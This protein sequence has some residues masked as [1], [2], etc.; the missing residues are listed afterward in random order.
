MDNDR[1]DTK[2]VDVARLAGCSPATVSRVLNNNPKVDVKVRD[3]VV[4][5]AAQLGYVPNGS[6]RALR[7]T[8][9]RTVGAII[10]TLDHAIYAT[11]VNSLQARLSE[12][13]VSVIINTSMYDIDIEFEQAKLLVERGVESVVLVGSVHR[14]ETLAMLEQRNIAY[15]FTY[16]SLATDIGAAIGF[17]NVKAGAMAARYLVDLGHTQLGMIAGIT[18]NNDRA[19]ARRDGFLGELKRQG[20]ANDNITV[21]ESAYKIEGGRDSMRKLMT[22]PNPP[23]AVFCGSDIIAAGAIKYCHAEGIRVPEDVS[24]FGFDNLEI[25]ELTHPELTTI[26]VPARDMGTIAAEYLLATPLQR[27]H[28]RQREL[29]LKLVVRASTAPRKPIEAQRCSFS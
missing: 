1:T 10:P 22:G 29:S 12:K 21:T 26:E 9:T 15:V 25:A 19:S 18:E 14:P 6:A 28:M 5:A 27:Q 2:L 17:D 16:T 7:S 20:L 13:D 4:K 23:S 11:M 24:V 8:K 3:R